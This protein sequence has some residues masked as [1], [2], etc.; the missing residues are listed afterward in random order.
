MVWTNCLKFPP[1]P[2]YLKKKVQQISTGPDNC[3]AIQEC[4]KL[5]WTGFF[6][7]VLFLFSS[8]EENRWA[9]PVAKIVE[10][11]PGKP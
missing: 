1:Y 3:P 4:E 7:V 2:P 11:K 10:C 8:M 6:V 5:K 9:N